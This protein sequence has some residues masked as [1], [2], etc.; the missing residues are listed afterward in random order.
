MVLNPLQDI[1]DL[2]SSITTTTLR[3]FNKATAF[4]SET[5]PFND[6]YSK[7]TILDPWT[8]NVD[9]STTGWVLNSTGIKGDY[10]RQHLE[11]ETQYIERIYN[12]AG[13]CMSSS[14]CCLNAFCNAAENNPC[15]S[16]DNCAY[17][18]SELGS[19]IVA[20]YEAYQEADNIESRLSADLGVQCPSRQDISCP[21]LEFQSM[22]NDITLVALVTAYRANITGTAD[23]LVDVASTS[24]GSAMDE[25][26][27]F[28]CNMN[29][30]FVQ[31]RYDQIRNDV[32]MT[33]F[34]GLTQV[35]WALWVLAL[36]LQATAILA[37]VLSTRLQGVSS[38]QAQLDFDDNNTGA[39]RSRLSRAELYGR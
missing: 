18:C 29:V 7:A 20:G 21:T 39:G 1:Q 6:T 30:S 8:A 4:D 38:E 27:D 5:C 14:S 37:N 32:C 26:Q 12:M 36:F 19:A 25:V 9:K 31:R 16:G 11:N 17:I 22:G 24:V 10:K 2:V 33:M 28:L 15:N 35:N 34:G 13:M 23:D 3:V